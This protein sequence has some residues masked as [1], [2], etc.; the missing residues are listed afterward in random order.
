MRGKP[1]GKDRR[2]GSV[3]RLTRTQELQHGGGVT[4]EA[5]P[6]TFFLE[7]IVVHRVVVFAEQCRYPTAVRPRVVGDGMSLRK[8]W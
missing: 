8:S 6:V 4:P 2:A 7:L 5:Y 3:F 1:G